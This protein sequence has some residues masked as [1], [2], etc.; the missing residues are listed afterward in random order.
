MPPVHHTHE[1]RATS[2]VATE[3]ESGAQDDPIADA[4]EHI[5]AAIA[6]LK[7]ANVT[8]PMSLHKAAHALS[9]Y[10]KAVH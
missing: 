3:V 5:A 4:R 6:E 8:V 7:A 2:V 9:Y 1:E 10:V